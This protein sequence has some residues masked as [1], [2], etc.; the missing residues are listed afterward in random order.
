C[1][2]V[3]LWFYPEQYKWLFYIAFF[4][5]LAAISMTFF[6]KDRKTNSNITSGIPI[7]SSNPQIL[8]SSNQ[9]T[10]FFSYFRYWS[11]ASKEYKFLVSGLLAFTLFNSSDAFL[12]F[13]LKN[14]GMSDTRMI[15]FYIF[16]N[17]VYALL[18][19]PL[20]AMA[21]RIG[22]KP[23]I[24]VGL[25]IFSVVYLLF[26]FASTTMMFGLLF[27][28]YGIYAASTEGISKALISNMAKKTET[29]TAIGFYNS[30]ASIFA[31]LASSLAGLLWLKAGMQ[32]MFVI[33][34]LGVFCVVIYLLFFLGRK[35][36]S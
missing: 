4:P 13:A 3:F 17:L 12:L 2:L 29:A 21:D 24:I 35:S 27:L 30:F 25:F 31:L 1:A 28:L 5:G 11:K 8:K 18:S 32:T 9:N 34:G 19:Y 22:L 20:G 33:S 6:L 36:S 15:G 23:T 16:Y 14:Q 7:K 10:G 26:G